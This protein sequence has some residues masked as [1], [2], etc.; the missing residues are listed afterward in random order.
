V[1]GDV[2]L[3]MMNGAPLQR[4]GKHAAMRRVLT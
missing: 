3:F 2:R 1:A 4:D